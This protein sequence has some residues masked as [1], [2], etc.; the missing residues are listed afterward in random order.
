MVLIRD[1]KPRLR[2]GSDDP[3][4]PVGPEQWIPERRNFCLHARGI[5]RHLPRDGDVSDAGG[6]AATS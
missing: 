3:S 2:Y 1:P 4:E 6:G 5:D